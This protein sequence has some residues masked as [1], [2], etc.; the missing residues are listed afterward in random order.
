[1]IVI[2]IASA[3]RPEAIRQLL[4]ELKSQTIFDDYEN[5]K[6]VIF[7][8]TRR[9][10]K[11]VFDKYIDI[12]NENKDV[13]FIHHEGG[14]ALGRNLLRRECE[15]D[16]Y[17]VLL[18]DDT[19]PKH[20]NII[21]DMISFLDVYEVDIVSGVWE[22]EKQKYR[23]YGEIIELM[24]RVVTRKPLREN[25][26]HS[27]HIPLATL[28]AKGK[29]IRKVSFDPRIEFYGDMFDIGMSIKEKKMNC[30]YNT[31]FIFEHKNI[32]NDE[33][34]K[35]KRSNAQWR[36]LADKWNVSLFKSGRHLP[37]KNS[38]EEYVSEEN[39]RVFIVEFNR[40]HFETI[41]GYAMLFDSLGFKV[42]V[43][44]YDNDM[45]VEAD[46][47]KTCLNAKINYITSTQSALSY[48]ER[49]A[50]NSDFC[51]LNSSG[52]LEKIANGEELRFYNCSYIDIILDLNLF[53]DKKVLVVHHDAMRKMSKR[54]S[55]VREICLQPMMAKIHGLHYL[56]PINKL[57]GEVVVEREYS[58]KRFIVA[59]LVEKERRDYRKIQKEFSSAVLKESSFKHILHICG[60]VPG[61]SK[62]YMR[63]IIENA[64]K[65]GTD[66]CYFFP[67]IKGKKI[68]SCVF[69]QSLK[70]SD[71]IILGTDPYDKIHSN[72]LRNKGSGVV[73]LVV[74]HGVI[75]VCHKYF[76]TAFGIGSISVVY[77]E[78]EK[79][80]EEAILE[81][82]NMSPDELIEYKVKI[83]D[84]HNKMS[85]KNIEILE[86]IVKH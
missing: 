61:H 43:L 30:V 22:C 24:G 1:M 82:M 54:A 17:F 76:A 31:D 33:N 5:G 32:P 14:P 3:N 71:F 50:N 7:N 81:C 12:Q 45:G 29:D 60:A 16:D 25:G 2:G 62:S 77:D 49:N 70:S 48:I 75:P 27:V 69:D 57:K 9:K 39:K 38:F 55:N 56:P 47:K 58:S 74:D 44:M 41:P 13:H 65:S 23:P 66:C 51:F 37:P 6:I 34:V 42:E 11:V 78:V 68:N 10:D 59:G 80:L 64:K 84:L 40:Y 26:V 79:T 67:E 35:F 20:P 19:F 18:D 52:Y 36:Y 21:S 85:K 83:K 86:K 15:D 73:G 4:P 28:A 72:Y 46:V 63:N 8:G 53:E